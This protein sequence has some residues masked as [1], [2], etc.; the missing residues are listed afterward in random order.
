MGFFSKKRAAEVPSDTQ[1]VADSNL[2]VHPIQGAP[3]VVQD[4]PA[5][6][7]EAPQSSAVM[8][9]GGRLTGIICSNVST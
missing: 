3:A 9:H 6:P 7:F 4:G 2:V 8:T 1:P 5:N